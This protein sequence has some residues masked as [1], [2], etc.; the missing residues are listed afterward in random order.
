M[1][2]LSFTALASR[3]NHL[4]DLLRRRENHRGSVARHSGWHDCRRTF[5]RSILAGVGPEP[6]IALPKGTGLAVAVV[7]RWVSRQLKLLRLGSEA[8]PI[9]PPIRPMPQ[10]DFAL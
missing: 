1:L 2:S 3:F 8:P 4:G 7:T 6:Q 9:M 10:G 5:F